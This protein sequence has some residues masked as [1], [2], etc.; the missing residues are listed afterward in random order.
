MIEKT[1]DK[2][3]SSDS[4]VNTFDIE[5]IPIAKKLLSAH[6]E[7]NYLIGVTETG[8]RFSFRIPNG[9]MLSKDEGG[10][11]VFIPLRGDTV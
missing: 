3:E 6:Q 8:V 7:G 1:T 5:Q 2:V 11:W 9:K 10:N 4:V